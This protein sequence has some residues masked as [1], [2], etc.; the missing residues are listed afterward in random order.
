MS[1]VAVSA[2]LS[3]PFM[4]LMPIFARRST[5]AALSAQPVVECGVQLDDVPESG[6]RDLWAC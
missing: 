5:L 2:F 6:S 1:L 4:T 3:M